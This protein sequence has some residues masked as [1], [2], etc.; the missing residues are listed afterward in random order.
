MPHITFPPISLESIFSNQNLHT[1][2]KPQ[3]SGRKM[4]RNLWFIAVLLVAATLVLSQPAMADWVYTVKRGDSLYKIARKTGTTVKAIRNRNGLKS[5]YIRIGQR[6]TIPTGK[7]TTSKK[8]VTRRA[9]D[10]ELLARIIH[11]EAGAEPYTGKVAVGAVI[12][13]R[14]QSP[15]FPS[16]IAGVVYQPHAFESVS[17]G[18]YTR[19]ASSASKK[20]A[21][22]A[23]S[24][25]DPSGGALYFFNPAKTRSAWMWARKIIN[26]IGKHVFAL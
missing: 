19:P 10:I 17:N 3:E 26:R 5:S 18:I 4:K 14:V 11:A 22:D 6:I 7:T 12:L 8:V 24:G 13:N 2:K 9:G 21:Q 1:K 16:T 25:W 20:A 15:K 23:I